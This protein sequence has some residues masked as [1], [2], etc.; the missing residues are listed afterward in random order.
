M[1]LFEVYYVCNLNWNIVDE[2]ISTF[3][4]KKKIQAY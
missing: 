4:Q 2:Q 3:E 1:Y